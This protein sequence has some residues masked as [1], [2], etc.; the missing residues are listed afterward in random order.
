MK[1]TPKDAVIAIKN[2]DG[3]IT[4]TAL[5]LGISRSHLH[6]LINNHQVIKN[7]LAD[8]KENRINSGIK[9]Y[10]SNPSY[11]GSEFLY[12]I[13]AVNGLTKIGIT[14]NIRGRFA[15]IDSSSPIDLH[16]V[17]L[18]N[19]SKARQI[20]IELHRKYANKRVKGEWFNLDS[21]NIEW[22]K[23]NYKD[24]I[25]QGDDA[26]RPSILKGRIRLLKTDDHLVQKS[27]FDV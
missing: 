1:V 4:H 12:L 26:L 27:F 14:Q 5:N 7:A 21:D 15:A 8:V 17:Y 11:Q 2:N 13:G 10:Y 25:K 3:N 20:E 9:D 18:L 23:N 16:V 22:I 24:T 6:A 19:S